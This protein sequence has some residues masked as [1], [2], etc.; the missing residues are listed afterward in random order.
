MKSLHERAGQARR[1][2]ELL[3]LQ[4]RLG[5]YRRRLISEGIEITKKRGHTII[6]RKEGEDLWR[7]SA[8]IGLSSSGDY[9]DVNRLLDL[10]RETLPSLYR[11]YK[12]GE[13][14]YLDGI[15]EFGASA[16]N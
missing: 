14:R 16:A 4:N 12:T 9:T 5:R 15:K 2:N 1:V 8:V 7:D 11:R 3:V 10:A 6:I 13:R